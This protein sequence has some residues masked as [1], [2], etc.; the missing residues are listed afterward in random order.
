[1]ANIIIAGGNK[2]AAR[3]T[4]AHGWQNLGTLG[5]PDSEATAINALGQIVGSSYTAAGKRH[6]FLWTDTD[7]MR[8]LGTLGG[9]VSR[10]G[11]EPQGQG[12]SYTINASE[13]VT[14]SSLTADGQQHAFRWSDA[15]GM[16]DL[17]TLG[18]TYSEGTNINASGQVTGSSLTA[19]GAQHAFRW[20]SS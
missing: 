11:Q 6:A 2:R 13:E 15:K 8:D 4:E 12:L 19:A 18:G 9:P 3:W 20:A 17:G 10:A 14:G 1:M 7:G 16:E 5:G